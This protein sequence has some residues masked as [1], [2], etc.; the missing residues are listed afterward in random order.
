M[1]ALITIGEFQETYGVSR[2]T[3]YRLEERGSI[4]FFKIVRAVRIRCDEAETWAATLPHG[5]VS[6]ASMPSLVVTEA[7]AGSSSAEGAAR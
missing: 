7:V 4:N 5:G 3:V 1:K 2:S 6:Q